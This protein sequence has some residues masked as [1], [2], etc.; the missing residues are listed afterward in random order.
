MYNSNPSIP[1]AV[2][3]ELLD[4]SRNEASIKS[5]KSS[6]ARMERVVTNL[7]S[8]GD[9][10]S[11]AMSWESIPVT[12]FTQLVM[13]Y[14]IHH[15][16]MFFPMFFLGIALQSLM[17]FPSRYQRTLDRCVPDDWLT[18][19]LAFAPDS[20]EE[21]ERKRASEAEAKKKLEEAKKAEAEEEK[22][23]EAAQKEEA[24]IEAEKAEAAKPR[25]VFSFDKLNPLAAL[26][27]QMDEITKMITDAQV[28]LDDAAG[29]L[30]RIVSIL[31]WDEPR[32]TALVVIGLI[33]LAWAFIFIDAVVRFTTHVV[34]GVFLKTFFTI[35]SPIAIKWGVSFTMLFTFRHP[36]ILP[37]AATAAIEEEKRVRRAAAEAE[38][39][40]QDSGAKVESKAKGGLVDNKAAVFDPR[41]IAPMNIFYRIPTQAARVL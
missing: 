22:R 37:D 5:I 19:G 11:Y 21:L 34:V 16:H 30:E 31:D 7:T 26:Q 28:V 4:F 2:S 9:G 25:E 40:A 8:V 27:R 17:R 14:V 10:F 15:P 39:E 29:I 13:V 18:V 38:A 41:P 12:I 36:A 20:E 35:F 24:R 33:L 23:R 1:E 6:I 3:K 32:V